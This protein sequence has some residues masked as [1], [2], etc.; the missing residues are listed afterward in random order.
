MFLYEIYILPS[1]CV[2]RPCD[3]DVDRFY[4]LSLDLWVQGKIQY[5]SLSHFQKILL[6][7]FNFQWKSN[8]QQT[9]D[10][11]GIWLNYWTIDLQF[12]SQLTITSLKWILVLHRVRLHSAFLVSFHYDFQSHMPMQIRSQNHKKVISSSPIKFTFHTI[13]VF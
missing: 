2:S 8:F 6:I 1:P 7:Y 12:I 3:T 11:P 10:K 9:G 5:F 13:P 4:I